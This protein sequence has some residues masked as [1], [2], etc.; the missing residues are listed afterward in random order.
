MNAFHSFFFLYFNDFFKKHMLFNK[1]KT[2]DE[3]FAP[4]I[5]NKSFNL[6]PTT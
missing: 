3:K 6:N 2:K 5:S 1:I 4:L